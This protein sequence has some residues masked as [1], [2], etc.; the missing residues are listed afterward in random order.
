MICPLISDRE[1]ECDGV[2]C[3]WWCVEDAQCAV[4]SIATSLDTIQRVIWQHGI[5]NGLVG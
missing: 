5:T 1:I 4:L 3:S 2:N